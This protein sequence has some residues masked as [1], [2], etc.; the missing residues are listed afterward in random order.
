MSQESFAVTAMT[1][2]TTPEQ[3][4]EQLRQHL[5]DEQCARVGALLALVMKRQTDE[6]AEQVKREVFEWVM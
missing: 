2:A 4:A 5:A 3:V 6:R 1:A